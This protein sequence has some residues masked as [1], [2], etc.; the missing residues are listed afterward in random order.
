MLEFVEKLTRYPWLMV[1][2]DVEELRQVGF[3][4]SEILQIVLGCAH[5]N[6]LNR[7]ADGIG[8]KFEYATSIPEFKIPQAFNPISTFDEPKGIPR[9][10]RE[11]IAWINSPQETPKSVFP[12]QPHNL[13]L[14][15]GGNAEAR[16]LA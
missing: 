1:G 5:F 7:M 8:I 14:A 15:M 2:T 16:D 3:T 10:R 9:A 4:D 11:R 6:Y 12:G 13:Y